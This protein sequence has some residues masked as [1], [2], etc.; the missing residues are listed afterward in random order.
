MGIS[1]ALGGGGA[2]G[3]AHV[4]VLKVLRR[5]AI[6]V[7][8]IAGTSMGAIIGGT[9]AAG[10]PV[11]Q[12]EAFALRVQRRRDQIRL[13]DLKLSVSGSGLLRGT[14]IYRLLADM[15]GEQSTF[16]QLLIPFAVVA[17]DL[18]TG[19]E[20]VLQEGR[21]VEA[22]RATMS[23]PGVFEPVARGDL[24]L[25]DGG[26][27]NNLPVDV[28]RRI[29][30]G[31]VVAV[32]VLPNFPRNQAGQPPVVPPLRAS[33]L[34]GSVQDLLHAYLIMI[35]QLT[36]Y[37]LLYCPADVVIRPELPLA[38]G[39]LNGFERVAELIAAGEAAAQAALPDIRQAMRLFDAPKVESL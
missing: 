26:V 15:L 16:D 10:V 37:R 9:Y 27:L 21:L 38:V 24:L 29:G 35:A 22:V 6:P 8:A 39:L 13:V 17:T 2:R 19:R 34:P 30:P 7:Q 14:R 25:A 4:G 3:L 20:V 31:P 32:D 36:E 12:I 5:E 28:A 18:L 23:V 33:L 11:E 1:L